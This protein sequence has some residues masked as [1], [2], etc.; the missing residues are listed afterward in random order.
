[1]FPRHL[2]NKRLAKFRPGPEEKKYDNDKAKIKSNKH[3]CSIL[4][5]AP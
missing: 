5:I 4:E 1:M 2:A 3:L